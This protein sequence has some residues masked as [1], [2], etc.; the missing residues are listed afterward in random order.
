MESDLN[1]E[2]NIERSNSGLITTRTQ[3]EAVLVSLSTL[4][5]SLVGIF[6]ACRFLM[7]LF[8]RQSHEINKVLK[9]RENFQEI[10]SQIDRLESFVFGKNNN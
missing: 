2:I 9:S 1:V 3:K 10:H 6:G 7:V 5:G 4:V 8:E